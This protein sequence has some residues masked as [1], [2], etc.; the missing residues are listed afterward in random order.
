MIHLE[1]TLTLNWK[2]YIYCELNVRQK[3]KMYQ[4]IT[5]STKHEYK[6]KFHSEEIRPNK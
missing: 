6:T 1:I 3:F 5:R 2:Q 4:Q